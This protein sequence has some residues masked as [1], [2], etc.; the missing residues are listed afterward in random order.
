MKKKEIR[1]YLN[2]RA[3]LNNDNYGSHTLHLFYKNYCIVINGYWEYYNKLEIIIYKFNFFN[4]F[5]S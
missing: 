3:W 5:F 2:T 1:E 4:M